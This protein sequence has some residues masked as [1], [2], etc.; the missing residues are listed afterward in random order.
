M[1]KFLITS[2]HFRG[3]AEILYREDGVLVKIDLSQ[4]EMNIG[5]TDAFKKK[6][7]AHLNDIET[8]FKDTKATVIEADFEVTFEMFWNAY[9]KKINRKRCEPIWNKLSK[10]KQVKAY[11]GIKQYDKYLKVESWR[12]KADP[13]TYLRNETFENEYN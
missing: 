10:P 11:Y 6:V 13:D 7:P 2:P 4:C 9:N 1:R 8:A 5:I 3:T 12:Q